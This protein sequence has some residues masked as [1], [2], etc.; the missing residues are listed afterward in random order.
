MSENILNEDNIKDITSILEGLADGEDALE[1]FEAILALPDDSF[2][3][4]ASVVLDNFAKSI[5]SPNDK[6]ILLQSL[7]SAGIKK[8]ELME[9]F[10]EG[11]EAIKEMEELSE[12]KKDFFIQILG[13]L[14]NAVAET[15]GISKRIIQI[16]IELC[17]ENAKIPQYAHLS[18]SG[19]DVFAIDDYTIAPGETKL[20]PTGLKVAIPPGY[21]LQVRPKSGRALKTKLRIANTPGTIDAGYRDEIGIIVENVDPPI[22]AIHFGKPYLKVLQ[23][24]D[25]IQMVLDQNQLN[26][27]LPTQ[28][29]KA[30]NSA[31]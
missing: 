14:S 2:E 30:K 18:D 28:S 25:M 11:Y 3:I 20:I 8:E 27:V 12:P 13:I 19:M 22:R 9:S 26:M 5:N 17:H 7:N 6:L 10:N 24:L 4:I 31:S 29:E 16:P 23:L 1:N 21:E 15:E